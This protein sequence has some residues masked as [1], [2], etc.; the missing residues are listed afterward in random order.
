MRCSRVWPL[1]SPMALTRCARRA[2]TDRPS[3]SEVC[4]ALGAGRLA[5]LSQGVEGIVTTPP[6]DRSFEPGPART[7]TLQQRTLCGFA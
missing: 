4:P 1:A 3:G 5:L 7:A 2:A 6:I